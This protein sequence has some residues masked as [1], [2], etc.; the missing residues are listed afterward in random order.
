[1]ATMKPSRK[2]PPA[3]R[4]IRSLSVTEDA[5]A[6]LDRLAQD[7]SDFTGRTV[8]GSAI[9]RA[10]IRHAQGQGT[11]WQR[12]TLFPVIETELTRGTSW[13]GKGRRTPAR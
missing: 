2:K 7:A 12:S 6:A 8:S 5:S 9:V 11:D 13:G 4:L 3:V 10:L 1:M